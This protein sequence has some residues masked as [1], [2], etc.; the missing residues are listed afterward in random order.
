M[1][2]RTVDV[3]QSPRDPTHMRL[4]GE[5]VY[6]DSKEKT[7]L[8]WFEVTAEYSGYLD[9]R[10]GNPW[11]VCLL[12]LAVTLGEPLRL[13]V[14]VDRVLYTNV[15]KLM[16]IW[17]CWHPTLGVVPLEVELSDRGVAEGR[18]KIGSFFSGGIDSFF[19]ALRHAE[20]PEREDQLHLDDLLMVWGLDI[21]IA[22][23][24]VFQRLHAVLQQAVLELGK[25]LVVIGT[26]LRV[27]R[28]GQA[29]Y[30]KLSHGCGLA[31]VAHVLAARY[32]TILIASS[33]GYYDLHP[34][35]SHVLTDPLLSSGTLSI[36]HDGAEF[37]RVQK[38]QR[39][40]QSSV[41]LQALHI[42]S[43]LGSDQNCGACLKCCRTMMTL[44]LLGVLGDCQTFRIPS[45]YLARA[46]KLY[47]R[48][49][50]ARRFM[51][52]IRNLALAKQRR[53]VVSMVDR[54]FRYS[55]RLDAMLSQLAQFEHRRG[56]RWVTGML[57]RWLLKGA[58]V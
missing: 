21:P 8:Y 7:E 43:A 23:R 58:V 19:T 37:N 20:A 51:I 54:S 49:P 10:S 18:D 2:L 57:K 33:S 39:I 6:D 52:E 31:A 25:S 35:G 5:V 38:T 28:W 14:P 50:E 48:R 30:G 1:Q 12:P 45:D 27:T 24:D 40:A 13:C 46:S 29:E 3:V 47:L 9:N 41:A 42:C 44:D 15:Q 32:H 4:V 16:Q 36:Q 11:L 22:N 53:D 56:A 34:W 26:N 17:R 55:R